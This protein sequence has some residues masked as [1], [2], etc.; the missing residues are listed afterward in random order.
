VNE[1]AKAYRQGGAIIAQRVDGRYLLVRKPR[2]RHAWQFPQ[3]G[4]EPNE[5]AKQ[6]ALRE[7]W[8]EIGTDKVEIGEEEAIFKYDYPANP[9]FPPS[10]SEE[11]KTKYVGQE[12]HIFYGQFLGDDADIALAPNELV[13]YRWVDAAE[14]AELV[15][16]QTYLS[17]CQSIIQ[18]HAS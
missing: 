1:T 14:I 17:I 18:K 10:V 12:I 13:E 5:T 3:G 15:E 9:H 4:L 7:F 6:A 2:A 16:D 11:D 8:E